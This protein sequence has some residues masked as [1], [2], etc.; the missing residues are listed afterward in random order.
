RIGV[1]TGDVLATTSPKPGEAMVTGDAVNAASR[2]Q[3]AA[4]P[5]TI[6]AS[7]RTARA[8]RGFAFSELGALELKGKAEPVVAFRVSGETPVGQER[9]VPGLRAPMVGRDAEI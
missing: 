8:V 4:E 6:L 7:E 3:S 9:G 5:G 1:N 2:L